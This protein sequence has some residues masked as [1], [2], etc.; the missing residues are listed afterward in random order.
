MIAAPSR[1]QR[2]A[3]I[4]AIIGLVI[5]AIVLVFNGLWTTYRT[6]ATG[7]ASTI[8]KSGEMKSPGGSTETGDRRFQNG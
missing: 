6:Q 2:R 4:G 1:D 5:V 7:P 8:G 3:L